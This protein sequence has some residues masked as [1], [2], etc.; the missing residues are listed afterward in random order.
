VGGGEG[1]RAQGEAGWV[2]SA[3]R[4]HVGR[5]GQAWAGLGILQLHG[6]LACDQ[7]VCDSNLACSIPCTPCRQCRQTTACAPSSPTIPSARG[8]CLAARAP[9]PCWTPPWVSARLAF[10]RSF[11]H[12]CGQ[13][14]PCTISA[15]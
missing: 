13:L 2:G 7:F 1:S 4:R 10:I 6:M 12:C 11:L 8:C 3:P 15:T 5:A 14:L 9:A